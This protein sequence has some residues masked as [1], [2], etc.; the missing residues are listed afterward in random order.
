MMITCRN[1]DCEFANG[2][3]VYIVD[4]DI[5][6]GR[7]TLIIATA[8]KYAGLPWRDKAT[9]LFNVGHPEPPPELIIQDE[10][11]LISGP[12]G[13]LAGLYE[14]AVDLLCRGEDDTPPKVIASTA[15]IRRAQSQVLGLFSRDVRQFPPPGLDVR[16]SWFAVERPR[17]ERG[18]RQYL[19]LMAPATSQT[20]LLVRTYGVLLQRAAELQADPEHRDP[21]WTLLG[22]FNSLRVLGGARMQVQ[23]DVP[24]YM[25]VVARRDEAAVRS[26]ESV[27]ELTSRVPSS[28]IPGILAAMDQ[29]YET[30]GALDLILA[31]N[32]ISVGVDVSR[33][34]LMAVMGQPQSASEY[35][36]ATSRIGRRYPGLV[37]VMF[38]AARS[39]DRSHFES[40]TAF[41][42]ALYRQVDSSSVTPFSPRARDRGLHAVLVALTRLTVAEL[43]PNDAAGNVTALEFNLPRVKE[44]ILERVRRVD[45]A[46]A[47]AVAR[48]L[49]EL[50]DQW[51]HR[52]RTVP[53][54]RYSN[55]NDEDNA[56]LVDATVTE[57]EPGQFPTLW[58]LRDVDTESGLYLV[59]N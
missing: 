12:L 14:T 16:D 57:P 5:Y 18:T 19:G 51:L 38:N 23:D 37:A 28:A 9:E 21:Y 13:T 40:F 48:N 17:N 56:L 26:V 58:S 49:D 59:R 10:L 27:E 46:E 53:G 33:L 2:L 43:R 11:H 20:T 24:G 54:L 32:M 6:N 31:T 29:P 52:A 30:Q 8:D 3:P 50:I 7:P 45:P 55:P 44:R 42:S 4:D 36:Q 41:H 47:D 39:R 25:A 15:T 35:I 1:D 34:G 22:Y